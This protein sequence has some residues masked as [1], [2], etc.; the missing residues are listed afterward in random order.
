MQKKPIYRIWVSTALAFAVGMTLTFALA[1]TVYQIERGKQLQEINQAANLRFLN[2]ESDIG[3]AINAV[4]GLHSLFAVVDSVT[5]EQF[6]L[7]SVP[8]LARYP[9]IRSLNYRVY[10]QHPE[11]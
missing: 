3:E 4:Y 5:R 8:V 2:I 11:R 7:F 9:Y 6:S 10:L 1:F